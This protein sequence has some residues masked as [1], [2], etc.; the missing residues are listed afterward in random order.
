MCVIY[1]SIVLEK[2]S[3]ALDQV[4]FVKLFFV[5]F[6]TRSSVRNRKEGEFLSHK[7]N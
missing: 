1:F 4:V 2:G 6:N 7:G 5:C 3:S